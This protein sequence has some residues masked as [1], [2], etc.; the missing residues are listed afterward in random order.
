MY[1]TSGS[2]VDYRPGL[3]FGFAMGCKGVNNNST[4]L[5]TNPSDTTAVGGNGR[6]CNTTTIRYP[7][8]PGRQFSGFTTGCDDGVCANV[9]VNSP[10]RSAHPGGV[11]GLLGDGSVRFVS[12]TIANSILASLA[13]RNDGNVLEDF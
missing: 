6:V 7:I 1:T 3:T 12:D 10:L 8:N 2:K 11:L 9:G 13:V 5:L 4:S